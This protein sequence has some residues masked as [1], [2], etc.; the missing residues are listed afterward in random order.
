MVPKIPKGWRRIYFGQYVH[1]GDRAWSI[2]DDRWINIITD[3]PY[4]A[5]NHIAVIIRRVKVKK[6]A[7][8]GNF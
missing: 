7:K 1:N 2:T 3:G 5:A 6:G 4:K 8:R